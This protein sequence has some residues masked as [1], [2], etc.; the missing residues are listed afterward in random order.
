M[1]KTSVSDNP[2]ETAQSTSGGTVSDRLPLAIVPRHVAIIMDGNNRWAKK[3]SKGKL[4]GHR[5]GVEA[6]RKVIESCGNYGVE[7]LTLFAFSSENWNRPPD[8]VKGLME[9][10]LRALKFEVKRLR[11]HHIRLKVIG[12]IS[13]FSPA[14]QK[15]IRQA[16]EKTATNYKVTLVVAASYGGQWDIVEAT[17]QL[18]EK[19]KS[20]QL[21]PADITAG[22]LEQH[23]V[24]GDLPPPDLLIRTSGEH[25]ISNFLLWQCAYSEFYFTDVLWPDFG[26]DEF[27]KALQSFS[28]RQRRFGKT[29]EQIESDA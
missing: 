11:R 21:D 13:A 16:E 18:A 2:A 23:L 28:Q 17:R 29:S 5:A 27:Y 24:T 25:R 8:E 4:G 6:V 7:V 15:H 20:G 26:P 14:I 9:L 19:A 12:D 22:M 3:H 10:F 1:T